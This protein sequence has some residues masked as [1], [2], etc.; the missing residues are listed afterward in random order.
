MAVD[1]AEDLDSV[2]A[3]T[4][5]RG[6]TFSTLRDETGM[7]ARGYNVQGIPASYFITRDGIVHST[8]VG[9]LD[10]AAIEANLKEIL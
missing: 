9:P 10:D 6:L 1:I 5:E 8:H 2:I 7:V 4:E 3:Y